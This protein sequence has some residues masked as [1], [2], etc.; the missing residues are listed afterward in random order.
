[1]NIRKELLDE[2]LQECK[3]PPDLFGEAGWFHFREGVVGREY[4]KPSS[5]NSKKWSGKS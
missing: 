3:T 1:M 2:L 4:R 5:Q